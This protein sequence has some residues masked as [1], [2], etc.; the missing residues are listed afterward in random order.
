MVPTMMNSDSL[1]EKF[2]PVLLMK[3]KEV[4]RLKKT[5][6][7]LKRCGTTKKSGALR[8]QHV[9]DLCDYKT[10]IKTNLTKHCLTHTGENLSSVTFVTINQ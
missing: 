5:T 9:C 7:N 6:K 2:V 8:K 10:T 3:T 1:L 4:K